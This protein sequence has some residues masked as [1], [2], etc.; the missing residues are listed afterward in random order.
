MLGGSGSGILRRAGAW[1]DII[2]MI[3]VIGAAGTVTSAA[4]QA[5][6]DATIAGKLARVHAAAS[7][8]GRDPRAIRFASTIFTFT[9]T[10]S[11]GA[12]RALAERL[13]AAYG[14]PAEEIPRHPIALI[15]TPEE[16]ITELRRRQ[17][18]HGL[19]MLAINFSSAEQ[20]KR[21]GTE[22]LPHV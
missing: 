16:M 4:L 8:A 12:T 5:F 18:V 17:Q 20:V 10:D 19:S 2:H 7:A 11:P 21:F 22:V 9:P 3:P 6:S 14:L 15:G 1:A 13:A